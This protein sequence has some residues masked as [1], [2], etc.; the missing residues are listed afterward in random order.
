MGMC[1]FLHTLLIHPVVLV[2]PLLLGCV[3]VH[4]SEVVQ[5]YAEHPTRIT[6]G[7][8]HLW[9]MTRRLLWLGQAN[10]LK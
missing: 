8:R 9:Y 3:L 5:L 7:F 1:S 10:D 2:V 4:Y 6:S